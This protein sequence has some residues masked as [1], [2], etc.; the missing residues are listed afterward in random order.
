MTDYM[1]EEREFQLSPEQWEI[2]EGLK[3]IGE[4]ISSLYFDGCRILTSEKYKSKSYLLMH[5]AREIDGGIRTIWGTNKP[6]KC[7]VCGK[8]TGK[9]GGHLESICKTLGVDK[10]DKFAQEWSRVAS[11]FYKLAHRH[12]AYKKAR[13]FDEAEELWRQFE[14]LLHGFIG[15][16][17]SRV[18]RV[19]AI[20]SS[21]PNEDI[22]ETSMN[23]ME[24]K[25][26]YR[27]FL[28]KLKRTDWFIPLK[29]KGCFLPEYNPRPVENEDQPGFYRIPHW[30]VL[31][32][33]E[34]VAQENAKQPDKAITAGLSE[35]F[36][37]II[38]YR[39]EDGNR[40]DNYY[41]DWSVVK[42]V[43]MMPEE[44]W[45]ERYIEFIRD[46]LNTQFGATL[47]EDEIKKTVLPLLIQHQK[48]ELVL[49]LLNIILDYRGQ[50]EEHEEVEPLMEEFWLRETLAKCKD[51]I[52]KVCGKD[53]A[54]VGIE[55][56]KK[57]CNKKKDEFGYVWIPSVEETSQIMFPDRY[58]YVLVS[59]VRD[60]YENCKASDIKDDIEENLQSKE[61]I[62]RRIAVHS[63]NH[64]Y[65]E[66]K[67][68]F[69]RWDKNLLDEKE[70]HHEIYVLIENNYQKFNEVEIQKILSW[71]DTV[72]IKRSKDE[73]E[74]RYKRYVAYKKKSWLW[75][76]KE[77]DNKAVRK[78][79]EEYH[80]LCPDEPDHPGFLMWH[81]E[82]EWR[83][84]ESPY[85]KEELL[86]KSNNEIAD[87]M[88]NF[89]E[90]G[91]WGE[92][93]QRGL[94]GCLKECVAE[95]PD[96][97][98]GELKPFLDIPRKYQ[99]SLLEG[100]TTAWNNK[101]EFDVCKVFDFISDL[102]RDD[103][104]WKEKQ[105]DIDYRRWVVSEITDFIREGTREDDYGF[106]KELF[107]KIED[108][109][110]KLFE[111][112]E[113]SIDE[114]K[115]GSL[116]SR[117]ISSPRGTV[118][119]ATITYALRYA[120][121]YKSGEEEKI[122]WPE[123]IKNEFT[124]RLDYREESSL[125]F[126]VILGTR[127]SNL[128]YLDH[129]WVVEHI[130]EIFP[131]KDNERWKASFSGYLYSARIYRNL[132]E[133]MRENGHYHKAIETL[134]EEDYLCKNV[135]Q[136]IC[137]A[138]LN[139]DE[140]ITETDS[141]INELVQKGKAVHLGKVV[142]FFKSLK[143]DEIREKAKGKIRPLWRALYKQLEEK[144][145]EPEYQRVISKL[146]S[147]LDFIDKIDEEAEGWLKLTARYVKKNY[148]ERYLVEKL[149][150]HVE[151]SPEAVA[152][153]F[154][155]MLGIGT[156]P[157]NEEDVK[158]IVQNLYSKGCKEKAD[159]ICNQYAEM[160]AYFLIDVYEK[161]AV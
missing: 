114:D 91:N 153:I 4:E 105:E 68:L 93:T 120:K 33:L 90:S 14:E 51:G 32:Y 159:R 52:I 155:E 88:K 112:V 25:G 86:E 96:K 134:F 154:T 72:T 75:P 74:G 131:K 35:I 111:K 118:F 46:A 78:K 141:L 41:T 15:S 21:E 136:H 144:K 37:S 94:S 133:L 76:L 139:D 22:V 115:G 48:K 156:Y 77:S 44:Q 23:L 13:K 27:Y 18:K 31:D 110:L 81:Y 36:D 12:G 116:V 5:L 9:E 57:I 117:V 82:P 85:K 60:V 113:S 137:I 100:F 50:L 66:L 87:I 67:D 11:K 128:L 43:F 143:K 7:S 69:W 142:Q 147:W 34:I 38:S 124:K 70:L 6:E 158:Q 138:Y 152:E 8:I 79:F 54:K 129:D 102:I 109:L 150:S 157:S 73:D 71:I 107:S 45:N 127:L 106:T 56:I 80:Q 132:Y 26:L 89:K 59:F 42:I 24:T 63:I 65:N 58:G 29:E 10:S 122:R 101:D 95:E 1:I 62:V 161:E 64:H 53:A 19:D 3:G 84:D 121:T 92:P 130:D 148:N 123:Q 97:F 40:I 160:G 125:D 47:V 146:F 126:S 108:I 149:V 119:Q 99:H 83:G 30:E 61:A 49:K 39:D 135:A 151:K 98:A 17:L 103:N 145:D 140:D 20:L 2:Y 104:F 55:K 28:K 16:F